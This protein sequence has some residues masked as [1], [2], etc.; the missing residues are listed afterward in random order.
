M[1]RALFDLPCLTL[2]SAGLASER[3]LGTSEV[4]NEFGSISVDDK[5]MLVE[6]PKGS[7]RTFFIDVLASVS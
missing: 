1:A 3:A 5:L 7:A 6:R 2:R 4:Q